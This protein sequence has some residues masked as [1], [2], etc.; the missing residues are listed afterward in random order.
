M[1]SQSAFGNGGISDEGG[2]LGNSLLENATLSTS[3][4]D[5]SAYLGLSQALRDGFATDPLATDLDSLINFQSITPLVSD[6]SS[7]SNI[8]P[9]DNRRLNGNFN[10]NNLTTKDF[11][12]GTTENTPLVGNNLSDSL[13][14]VSTQSLPSN[15]ESLTSDVVIEAANETLATTI[16]QPLILTG[17]DLITASATAPNFAS[18]NE[19]IEFTWTVTNVGDTEIVGSGYGSEPQINAA[20]SAA[21]SSSNGW[22]DAIYLSDDQTIDG[23]DTSLTSTW[24]GEK[25]PLGAGESYTF[26]ESITLPNTGI[27]NRYLILATDA[28]N[29]YQDETDETNN[30]LVLPIEITAPNLVIA[31][32]TAPTTASLGQ[33]IAV[34]WTGSNIG[35]IAAP[36][37]T[38]W[39]DGVYLSKDSIFDQTDTYLSEQ[40]RST[41][42]SLG[43]NSSYS[44]TENIT[45]P[46]TNIGK[47]YLLLVADVRN[48][49]DETNEG[50][51]VFALPIDITP[52]EVDLVVESAILPATS[53]ESSPV[54][55]T[56]TVT[57]TG[58]SQVSTNWYD[59]IYLS[60][61]TIFDS[62]DRFLDSTWVGDKPPLAG[63]ESY[64]VTQNVT[65]PNRTGGGK[66]YVLIVT[67]SYDYQIEANE[68]NNTLATPIELTI[69]D[70]VVTGATAPLNAVVGGITPVSWTVKNQGAV[71]AAGN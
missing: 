67:D 56:W 27:G 4:E 23:T 15:S 41:N 53:A 68:A 19:T 51:N 39:Y 31:T 42:T 35:D 44:L 65:L 66:W 50:D 26:T 55:L 25:L 24:T 40:Q 2:L 5:N 18:L 17:P 10:T 12:T 61:N 47:Q 20:L 28:Y 48:Q 9:D 64:S 13:T 45:I 63:G 6:S 14:G 33:T 69:P 1:E 43:V 59:S 7:T 3:L 22:Y 32:A 21:L 62:S 8:N 57:N 46:D 11:L 37:P 16:T 71:E 36:S 52:S 70:L 29:Y 38:D 60:D 34:D 54:A 30:T 49:Q 58:T